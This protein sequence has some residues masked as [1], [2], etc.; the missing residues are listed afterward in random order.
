MA[1]DLRDIPPRSLLISSW[2]DGTRKDLPMAKTTDNSVVNMTPIERKP[3]RSLATSE[4]GDFSQ[5]QVKGMIV[6][7]RVAMSGDNPWPTST[8]NGLAAHAAHYG[9]TLKF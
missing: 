3:K 8:L 9:I 1:V 5:K 2:Y 4:P 6:S 7:A